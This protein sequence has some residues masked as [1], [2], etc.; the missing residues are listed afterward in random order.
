[1][2]L[3][4]F[5][6]YGLQSLAPTILQYVQQ[7]YDS[8][9]ISVLLQQTDA[10]KKRFAANQ[11]R[12]ANGLSALSPSDYISMENQYQSIMRNAGLPANF[13]DQDS[14]FTDLIANNVSSSELSSRVSLAQQATENADPNYVNAL[15]QMGLS[16]GDITAYYLDPD[17]A[18]PLLQQQANT[19][20]IGAAALSHGLSFDQSYA[21][22]LTQQGVTAAQA[23]QGYGQIAD[24][25]TKLQGIASQYGLNYTYGQEEQAVFQPG[26]G[27]G[28]TA[29]QSASAYQS[30]L[31]SWQRA[32]VSGN[33][34]GAQGGLA[35]NGGGALS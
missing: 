2:L 24:E 15:S 5:T 18:L 32:N 26:T 28:Q 10:Y 13:Y 23:N 3:S 27:Q 22:T 16:Q 7:G 12:I 14:D 21:N 19:A 30:Q 9:T 11:T 20:A 35:R 17:K 1:M 34:G 29:G 31:A 6:T 33:V 25:F 8:D 4:T